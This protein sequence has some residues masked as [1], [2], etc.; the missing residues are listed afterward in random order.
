MRTGAPWR[1]LPTEYGPWQTVASRFY[2]W[3]RSGVWGHILQT[4]HQQADAKG[5]I[6]WEMQ[7]LDSKLS[8]GRINTLPARKSKVA[9]KRWIVAKAAS[10]PR[11][12]C[13]P[14]AEASLWCSCSLRDS[15]TISAYPDAKSSRTVWTS[16]KKRRPSSTSI[17]A[18]G[19]STSS[20]VAG[21]SGRGRATD[22]GQ[23][24]SG[25][26][27]PGRNDPRGEDRG[28]RQRSGARYVCPRK[29][30][31]ARRAGRVGGV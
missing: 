23:R 13:G 8:S 7:Y 3:G 1:D 31:A 24:R 21:V 16:A 5:Q 28:N 30:E 25:V 22:D 19:S 11:C 2:R 9:T 15:G 17:R 6:D 18:N 26:F 14:K 29:R 27:R 12:I 4:L 10:V 20:K